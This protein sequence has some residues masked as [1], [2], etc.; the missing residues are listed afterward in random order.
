[1]KCYTHG[2]DGGDV[3][4]ILRPQSLQFGG[5]TGRL[6]YGWRT[7]YVSLSGRTFSISESIQNT[8]QRGLG[9]VEAKPVLTFKDVIN[10][11][12]CYYCAHRL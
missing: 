11:L 1:M 4:R 9:V 5:S 2:R 12:S 8:C 10:K 3:A 6:Q 7:I